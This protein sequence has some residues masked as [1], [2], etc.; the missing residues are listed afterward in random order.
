MADGT[1]GRAAVDERADVRRGFAIRVGTF[2]GAL[3]L[4]YGVHVPY[5]PVWLDWRGLSASE[6]GAIMSA[7]FFLRLLVTPVTALFADRT[8]NHRRLIIALAWTCLLLAV[9]TSRMDAFWW[10]FFTAVPFHIAAATIMPL[11]ETVA[12]RGVRTAKLDYGRMRLWG[13]LTFI[14]A[15]LAGG[16]LIDGYGPPAAVWLLIAGAVATVLAAHAL[17][18]IAAANAT[19]APAAAPRSEC[20]FNEPAS[21]APTSVEP[22]SVEP[23]P[24]EPVPVAARPLVIGDALRLVRAPAFLIFLLCVGIVQ[25]THATFYTF[26]A[27]HW[28][29]QGLSTAWIGWLWAIAVMAEVA[30]FAWSAAVLARVGPVALLLAGAAAGVVRWSL[31]ALDPG[32]PVLVPLQVLHA[33]T[34]GASHLGAMHFI[35]RAVPETAVGTAQ[36]LYAT[37]A[38]GVFMGVVTLASGPLY[39]AGGG[40]AYLLPAALALIGLLLAWRLEARWSGGLLW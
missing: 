27:L 31:M 6:I 18:D 36:A 34:Y 40:L 12:V 39:A 37:F 22:S 3:F 20:K 14:A 38:A 5:L 24:V 33:L 7:P 16:T 30:L 2:Y 21:I 10:I 29:G 19:S 26:G 17:P 13:S 15:G 11:T 9:L 28:R 23:G 32:L 8:D 1:Q 25:A 4:I 35:A